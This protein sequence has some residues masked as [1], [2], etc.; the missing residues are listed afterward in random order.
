MINVLLQVDAEDLG[1]T[2]DLDLEKEEGEDQVKAGYALQ[3]CVTA[4]QW[5]DAISCDK[6]SQFTAV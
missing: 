1:E 2:E 6:A 3:A 4:S 5:V